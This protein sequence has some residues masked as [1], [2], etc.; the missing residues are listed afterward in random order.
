MFVEVVV[1]F[2]IL[3]FLSS[4]HAI[5]STRTEQGGDCVGGLVHH[6]PLHCGAD[7]CLLALRLRAV[8]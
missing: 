4:I 8:W 5:M 3:G 2:H 6:L 7:L 1:V